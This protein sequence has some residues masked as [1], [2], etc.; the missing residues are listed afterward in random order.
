MFQITI[1][2]A[3]SDEQWKVVFTFA[4][5]CAILL[6]IAQGRRRPIWQRGV[7]LQRPDQHLRLTLY[8]PILTEVISVHG[9]RK[10]SLL[11]TYCECEYESQILIIEVVKFKFALFNFEM[12]VAMY[13]FGRLSMPKRVN[14][15]LNLDTEDI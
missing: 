4:T 2:D 12:S 14:S 1:Q 8:D 9:F 10:V 7:E 11:E 13:C 6:S 3:V 5:P 15:Y